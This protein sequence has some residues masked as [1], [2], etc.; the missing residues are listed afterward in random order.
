M[1]NRNGL[2]VDIHVAE[3]SGFAERCEALATIDEQQ[4]RGFRSSTVG[5]D[6]AM[7]P[8]TSWQIYALAT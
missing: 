3:A 8:P 4:Q 5:A 6:K 1:E 7:T 2:C